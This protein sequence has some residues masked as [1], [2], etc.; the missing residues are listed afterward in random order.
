[1]GVTDV[2]ITNYNRCEHLRKLLY[3]L[4]Y[5]ANYVG[6]I[7]IVDNGS[8]WPETLDLYD[9]LEAEEEATIIQRKSNDGYLAARD[10]VRKL[11]GRF[12]ATDPDVFPAKGC[13][14]NLIPLLHSL[15]DDYPQLN[16]AGPGLLT[17]SIPT[18][19]ILRKR[20]CKCEAHVIFDRLPCNRAREAYL[21]TTFALY[22]NGKSWGKIKHAARTEPPYSFEH[23]DWAVDL[24]DPPLEYRNY[25][26]IASK[27]SSS[28]AWLKSQGVKL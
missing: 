1:M 22:R 20:I 15:L 16:K 9:E 6:E 4:S 25:Y 7:T 27:D 26:R 8:T 21:D 2:V 3:W 24:R 28:I 13:P 10:V 18:N 5:V 17:D 14:A 11:P 12:I 19:H 23:P